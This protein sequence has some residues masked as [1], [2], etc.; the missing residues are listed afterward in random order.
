MIVTRMKAEKRTELESFWRA[1]DRSGRFDGMPRGRLGSRPARS[2]GH[3]C[4][5]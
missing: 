1:T 3:N 4:T 2:P 5:A